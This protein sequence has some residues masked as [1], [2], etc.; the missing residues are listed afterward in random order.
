MSEEM[1]AGLMQAGRMGDV[2]VWG[3]FVLWFAWQAEGV[4]D[5]ARVVLA[6]GGLLTIGANLRNFMIVNEAMQDGVE[7]RELYRLS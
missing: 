2:L 6:G 3:P 7:C 4:P 5:W 1:Q